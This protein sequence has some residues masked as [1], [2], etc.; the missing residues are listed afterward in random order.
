MLEHFAVRDTLA[1]SSVAVDAKKM[2]KMAT[3][4]TPGT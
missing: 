1:N 4:A 2:V 3:A